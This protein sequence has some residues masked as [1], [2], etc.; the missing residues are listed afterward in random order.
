[1]LSTAQEVSGETAIGTEL[2]LT[3]TYGF[4]KGIKLVGGYSS[5]TPGRVFKSWKGT[6]FAGGAYLMTIFNF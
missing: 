4:R 6:D 1:M 5:F 2:D 3:T